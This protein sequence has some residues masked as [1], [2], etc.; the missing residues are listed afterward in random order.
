MTFVV[1]DAAPRD[2]ATADAGDPYD[3]GDG[4]RRLL[5]DAGEGDVDAPTVAPSGGCGCRA[6]GTSTPRGAATLALGVIALAARR[7]RRHVDRRIE[8]APGRRGSHGP[9]HEKAVGER[10]REGHRTTPMTEARTPATGLDGVV[11]AATP[12]S[13]TLTARWAGSSSPDTTLR[14]SRSRT[15]SPRPRRS[16]GA[17]RSA[18]LRA[19]WARAA[20]PRTSC[21]RRSAAPSRR[22]TAWT[23]CAPRRRTSRGCTTTQRASPPPWPCSPRRGRDAPK[24][25]RR[26]RPTP[27]GT[28]RVTTSAWCAAATFGSP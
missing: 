8:M 12:T 4:D 16:C 5:P 22:P 25:S 6:Q 18:T 13:A 3:A 1:V 19:R 14:P 9:V 20:R 28:T 15:R 23:R 21:S 11:V 10:P 27:R 24:G 17:R 26:S 2:V 7:R